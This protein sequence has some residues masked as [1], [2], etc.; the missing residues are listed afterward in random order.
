MSVLNVLG[1]VKVLLLTL[2]VWRG[3]RGRLTFPTFAPTGL[4]GRNSLIFESHLGVPVQLWGF[5]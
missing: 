5:K 1:N 3:G 2:H 4:G